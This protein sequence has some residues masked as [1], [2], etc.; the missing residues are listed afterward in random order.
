MGQISEGDQQEGMR[1]LCAA[2][3]ALR[4][5]RFHGAFYTAAAPALFEP[6]MQR[7]GGR[8]EARAERRLLLLLR[9]ERGDSFFF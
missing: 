9:G 2:V 1:Q 7:E 4:L 3:F 5:G 8:R 6:L